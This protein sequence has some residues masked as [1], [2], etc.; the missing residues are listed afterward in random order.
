VSAWRTLL[1]LVLTI[2]EHTGSFLILIPKH[3]AGV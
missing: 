3:D 2:C 1:F